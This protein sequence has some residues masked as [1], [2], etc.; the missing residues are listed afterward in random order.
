MLRAM[1]EKYQRY[2]WSAAKKRRIV[3]VSHTIA[4]V[5]MAMPRGASTPFRIPSSG[6]TIGKMT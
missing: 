3:N 4:K 6:M 2:L 5:P 1:A